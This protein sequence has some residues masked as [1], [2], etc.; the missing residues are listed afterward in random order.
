MGR[1]GPGATPQSCFQGERL[2]PFANI[3]HHSKQCLLGLHGKTL[4]D[5][6]PIQ[7]WVKNPALDVPTAL[8]LVGEWVSQR[9]IVEEAKSVL[10][11]VEGICTETEMPTQ[12][13]S[14]VFSKD[15]KK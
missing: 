3:Q 10:V 4:Q 2:F 14:K 9:E 5:G 7:V 12:F 11:S 8:S 1:N 13:L 15:H 6:S